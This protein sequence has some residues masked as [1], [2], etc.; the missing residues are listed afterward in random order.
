MASKKAK[1][2]W[3]IGVPLN[4]AWLRFAP[5]EL[6]EEYDSAPGFIEAFS[7]ISDFG[8]WLGFAKAIKTASNASFDKQK[9]EKHLKDELLTDLYNEQLIATAYRV[10]PSRSGAPVQIDS[11][12]FNYH[13][14]DW[15][16]G[17]LEANGIKYG[18]LKICDP[19]AI[20]VPQ[21]PSRGSGEAINSAI[22]DLI[23]D[24]PEFCNLPRKI[25]CQMVREALGEEHSLGNG[26][27]DKNIG[28]Y[29][30]A[31]CGKKRIS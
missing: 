1:L 28:K 22:S 21:K 26:L 7:R 23:Q 13:E 15:E 16:M 5:S 19:D 4:D 31:K 10:S 14:P 12:D 6:G 17:T 11:E 8:G 24:N 2:L 9:L 29:I 30:L 20:T 3:E 18:H 25:A 27:S